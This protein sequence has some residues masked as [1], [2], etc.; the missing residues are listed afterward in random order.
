MRHFDSDSYQR[1]GAF[2]RPLVEGFR[3]GPFEDIAEHPLVE[4][5][6][7]LPPVQIWILVR[8]LCVYHLCR[9]EI[10]VVR[11]QPRGDFHL[12]MT[13]WGASLGRLV[14]LGFS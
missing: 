11:I 4:V 3:E 13:E 10:F 9:G 14:S 2:K 6:I 12:D 8:T 7:L 5:N 1:F